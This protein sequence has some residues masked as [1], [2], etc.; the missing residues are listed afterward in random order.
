MSEFRKTFDELEA[1]LAVASSDL[2]AVLEQIAERA[3][4]CLASG[5]KLLVAGNGGSAA[6]AQHF[7]AELV[8]RFLRNRRGMPAIS[9]TTDTST[10]TAVANDYGYDRVFARQ[11]EALGR[12]EDLLLLLSTSGNSPN[13]VAAAAA[14]REIGCAVVALTGPGGGRL[15]ELSDLLLAVPSESTP[16]IQEIH[17][18]CLHLLAGRLEHDHGGQDTS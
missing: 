13:A 18:L 6:Q 16:R 17:L 10:L 14:A 12:S 15:A 9:L 4:G 11:V 1:L 3:G 8:G 2:I 5:G 7:A